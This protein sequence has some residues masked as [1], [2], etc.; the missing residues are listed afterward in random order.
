M[1]F[2]NRHMRRPLCILLLL[3]AC[4][5]LGAQ[6]LALQH[7]HA[8][9]DHPAACLL[10]QSATAAAVDCPP[11]LVHPDSAPHLHTGPTTGACDPFRPVPP[12]RG[13]PQYS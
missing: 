11:P 4:C 1:L 3:A 7:H 8:G 10:C 5:A 13:P 12:A 9:D 2:R 6:S